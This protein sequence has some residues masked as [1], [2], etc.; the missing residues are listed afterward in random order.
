MV[1]ALEMSSEWVSLYNVTGR[2]EVPSI[3]D[4]ES[5][6]EPVVSKTKKVPS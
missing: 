1:K 3:P 5:E 2:L 6:L 4:L